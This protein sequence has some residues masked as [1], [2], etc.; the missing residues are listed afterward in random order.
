[1]PTAKI[2]QN[3]TSAADKASPAGKTGLTAKISRILRDA[4][5]SGRLPRGQLLLET[6]VAN[7]VGSSRV[8]IKQAFAQLH[9]QGLISRFDGR[10]FIVGP[11][12]V[13]GNGTVIRAPITAASLGL[14]EGEGGGLKER[15]WEGVYDPVESELIH[16]SLYGRF[17][18]NEQELASR[19][20]VSRTVMHD[21]LMLAQVNGLVTKD[22]RSRWYSVPL[23][24]SRVTFLYELREHLEPVAL[25]K[26]ALS[27]PPQELERVGGRLT[28]ALRLYPKLPAE[29]LDELELDL[30]VRCLGHCPNPELVEALKRT[31][32]I[33]IFGKHL[34]GRE[35]AFPNEE[36]FFDEHRRIIDAM[37][38]R[39]EAAVARETLAHLRKARTKVLDRVRYSRSVTAPLDLPYIKEAG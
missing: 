35:I 7:L 13:P 28:E 2:Q 3:T 31:R 22:E 19:Y 17:R 11:D 23:D 8:P 26:A 16:C 21:V 30:H 33:L 25:S 36:P 4:I 38:R 15:A 29:T 5:L 39:D 34:L 32:C 20:G 14:E 27:I 24:E 9:A 6:H 18:I 12:P 1:M 37:M 10:G